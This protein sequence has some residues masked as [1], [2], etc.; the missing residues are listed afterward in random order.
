MTIKMKRPVRFASDTLKWLLPRLFFPFIWLL[1]LFS[2]LIRLFI[3]KKYPTLIE[4]PL[5]SDVLESLEADYDGKVSQGSYRSA[6]EQQLELEDGVLLA[7]SRSLT[8]Q[9]LSQNPSQACPL[10]FFAEPFVDQRLFLSTMLDLIKV[11]PARLKVV[12]ASYRSG[13]R[14]NGKPA[15]M[16]LEDFVIDGIAQVQH[17]IDSGISSKNIA[18]YGLGVGGAI[19]SQVAAYFYRIG[20]PVK[21]FCDRSIAS[22]STLLATYYKKTGELLPD[23]LDNQTSQAKSSKPSW[24]KSKCMSLLIKGLARFFRSDLNAVEAFKSIP[25][26]L[27]QA[28]SIKKIQGATVRIEDSV[29]PSAASLQ[30]GVFGKIENTETAFV[31]N[32]QALGRLALHLDINHFFPLQVLSA[33]TGT[34]ADQRLKTFLS[35]PT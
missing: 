1:D 5:E 21:L 8:T 15:L 23:L 9:Y 28:I 32:R 2:Y 4:L 34:T 20:S 22:V 16:S 25:P 12:L 27:C 24:I 6:K 18:L 7:P 17:Q 10:I 26:H 11:D 30:R 33:T 35:S 19:A 3:F 13:L 29:V 14:Q 31:I